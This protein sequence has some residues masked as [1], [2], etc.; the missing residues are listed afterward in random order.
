MDDK[1]DRTKNKG[2]RLRC[3][4]VDYLVKELK[5]D[6]YNG[7]STPFHM[8][9]FDDNTYAMG[10][11]DNNKFEICVR[12]SETTKRSYDEYLLSVM[13]NEEVPDPNINVNEHIDKIDIFAILHELGHRHCSLTK[14]YKNDYVDDVF[15]LQREFTCGRISKNEYFKE[16][17]YIPQE[18]DAD[19][20]ACTLMKNK[21]FMK[22]L[23]E[24]IN[25]KNI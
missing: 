24:Y 15:E 4:V 5:F 13:N 14:E 8:G 3:E 18:R 23:C 21:S 11:L 25:E 6:G 12:K 16:Y 7:T 1:N 9:L 20:F 22:K 17:R 2:Y 19:L 10:V